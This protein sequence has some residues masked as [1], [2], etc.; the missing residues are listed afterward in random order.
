MLKYKIAVMN[1]TDD[2]LSGAVQQF[3]EHSGA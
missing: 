2:S 1:V 3:K